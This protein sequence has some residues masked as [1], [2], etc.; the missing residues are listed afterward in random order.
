MMEQNAQTVSVLYTVNHFEGIYSDLRI[1]NSKSEH[2]D[3]FHDVYDYLE[4]LIIEPGV[5]L[6]NNIMKF[7]MGMP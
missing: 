1:V 3:D 6:I 4:S 5:Q 2:I 7:A